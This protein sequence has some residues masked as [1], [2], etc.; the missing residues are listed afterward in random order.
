MKGMDDLLNMGGF[1]NEDELLSFVEIKMKAA[2]NIWKEMYSAGFFDTFAELV[3][4]EETVM[5]AYCYF[6][7]VQNASKGTIIDMP[8]MPGLVPEDIKDELKDTS[9]EVTSLLMSSVS[10]RAMMLSAM[11]YGVWWKENLDKLDKLWTNG[12]IDESLS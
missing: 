4:N 6:I 12:A 3:S 10:L 9:L 11:M 8:Y 5:D 1:D 2:S 7:V